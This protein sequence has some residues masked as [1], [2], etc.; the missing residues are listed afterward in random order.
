MKKKYW[1]PAIERV[2]NVLTLI[3]KEPNKLKLMEISKISGINKSSLFSIMNTLEELG[4]VYKE[5]DQT[6]TLG[7]QLGYL[8]AKYNQQFDLT[9]VFEQEA[10]KTVQ[11][12]GETI[13]LSVLDGEDIVYRA[14]KEGSSV[15][16][17]ATEPGMRLP[18]HA[19]AMGKVLLSTYSKKELSEMYRDRAFQKLTDYTVDNLD[20][21]IDQ[22]ESLYQNGYI[23]E[24]EE[25]VKGFTCIAAPV[26]NERNDIIAAVSITMTLDSWV[27]KSEIAKN[28]IITLAKNLSINNPVNNPV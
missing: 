19:T 9:K 2:N 15:V 17:I 12:I 7:P 20:D 1:V 26:R 24:A 16:R 23:I 10:A 5:A 28:E 14:K 8:G 22:I 18:A 21:L 3:A 25:T 11:I 13:Q 4:W 27:E 6:Y